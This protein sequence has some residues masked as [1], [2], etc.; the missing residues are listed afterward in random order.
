M[1]PEE[2]MALYRCSA[3][4]LAIIE[5]NVAEAPPCTRGQLSRLSTILGLIPV[6]SEGRPVA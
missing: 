2:K 1:T 6:D 3:E 5:R 4:T